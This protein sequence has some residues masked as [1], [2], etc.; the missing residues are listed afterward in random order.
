MNSRIC[1]VWENGKLKFK[2]VLTTKAILY[3]F[4]DVICIINKNY[5]LSNIRSIK[6]YFNKNPQHYMMRILEGD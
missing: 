2:K 6:R 4:Y 5:S 1:V 3:D